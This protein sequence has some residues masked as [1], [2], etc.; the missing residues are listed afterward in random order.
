MLTNLHV[1]NLALIDEA[2]VA[3]GPGLNIPT[4]ETVAGKSIL[5]GSINLALGKKMTREVVREGASSCLVELVFQIENPQILSSLKA[6]DVET[7]DGQL[8][9]TRKIQDGRSISRMN[10]ETCTV[11]QIKKIASLLL[12]IHGQHE[13]Q[14]L[15]YQDRQLEIL[16]AYG[17]DTIGPLLEETAEKFTDYKKLQKELEAYQMNEE[18]RAREISFLEFEIQEIDEAALDPA[19]EEELER[20]YRKMSNS[21]K[22]AEALNQAYQLTGYEA[23]AGEMT[24]RALKELSGVAS[25]DEELEGLVSALTDIDGLLNDFNR[26][27]SAYLSDFTFSEEEFYETEKRLDQLNHLKSKYGKTIADVIDYQERQKRRLEQLQNFEA[28]RGLLSDRY[29]EAVKRLELASHNLSA[30]RKEYS[31]ELS[32]QIIIGLQELNFLDVS[33]EISFS[34][35]DHYN[36]SGFDEIEFMISTNPGEPVKPLAKVVSGGELSR[37]ML[38]IKTLLADKDNTETLIFDEI[39]TGISGRTAQKVSEKMARIGKGHQVLCITH[40]AQIAAMADVHFEIAKQVEHMETLTRIRRLSE[41]ESVQE[42][43]RILG[44]AEITKTV[45]DSAREMK[46]LAQVQKTSRLKRT[47]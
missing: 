36:K 41:S 38:A 42:L 25:F 44:G 27:V 21:R 8:I 43:A 6:M 2:E 34:R 11:S 37:I 13:H 17:R 31:R 29:E 46:E 15:L 16:D 33:F 20:R 23:G 10:G 1:N 32:K 30:K 39:D 5:I 12:D 35:T 3:F 40:L 7:E 9:I 28:R 14:S 19:E 4:G 26:D 22:I 24:G 45:Y 18:E 47:E